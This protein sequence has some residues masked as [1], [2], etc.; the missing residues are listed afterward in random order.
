MTYWSENY[1]LKGVRDQ[2]YIGCVV[3]V[4]FSQ[5]GR[6]GESVPGNKVIMATHASRIGGCKEIWTVFVEAGLDI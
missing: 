1:V 5:R 2:E 4:L 3:T 6:W